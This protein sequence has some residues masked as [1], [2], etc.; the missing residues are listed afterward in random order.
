MKDEAWVE[1]IEQTKR[2]QRHWERVAQERREI[3]DRVSMS[4]DL[5]RTMSDE[6]LND[7]KKKVLD[8]YKRRQD[9]RY[10]ELVQRQL[11]E[12]KQLKE[13]S[14]Y[15]DFSDAEEEK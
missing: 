13:K 6:S 10:E 1:S 7:M 3:E 4:D 14:M 11:E 9:I 15:M 12:S 8:E 5:Y 2:R